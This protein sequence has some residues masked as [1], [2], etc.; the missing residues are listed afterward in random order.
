MNPILQRCR[1]HGLHRG[2]DTTRRF[3]GVVVLALLLAQWAALV[4]AVDHAPA[5]AAAVVA[6]HDF[7]LWS[8]GAGSPACQAFDQLLTGQADAPQPAALLGTQVA[9][10]APA[11]RAQ[12]AGTR[13]A[14][15]AY[16]ARGPPLT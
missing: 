5:R 4:H 3:V 1:Q 14:L 6:G 8:H 7:A 10:A 15:R 2:L 11:A 16:E 12:P 9:D 13:P